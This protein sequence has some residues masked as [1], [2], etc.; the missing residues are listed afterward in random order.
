MLKAQIYSKNLDKKG[1]YKSVYLDFPV[2]RYDLN[3]AYAK[4]KIL[5]PADCG[6]KLDKKSQPRIVPHLERLQ[7]NGLTID[8]LN[9]F[10]KQ[11]NKMDLPALNKLADAINN[12]PAD[13]YRELINIA[14]D[15]YRASLPHEDAADEQP[16]QEYPFSLR[17]SK[18]KDGETLEVR[19]GLPR[20]DDA[21]SLTAYGLT[22]YGY[23]LIG[24]E[25][26]ISAFDGLFDESIDEDMLNRLAKKITRMNGADFVKY[27][28]VL[29]YEHIRSYKSRYSDKNQLL[30]KCIYYADE[31]IKYFFDV[32]V[33]DAASYAE[34]IL[35][36]A[37]LAQSLIDHVNL[38]SYGLAKLEESGA[39]VG[40]YGLV[41]PAELRQ[42]Q[43]LAQYSDSR[44]N[45]NINM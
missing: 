23:S 34:S 11:L 25:T 33:I 2:S 18:L 40:K 15:I 20:E 39:A 28:A 41:E 21:D 30:E 45:M 22:A 27:M 43:A 4:A 14:D 8:N 3:L 38:D 9:Y 36:R 6:I 44:E 13:D 17:M 1:V 5:S 10:A 12:N 35:A 29:D 16:D 24:V 42:E 31:Y 19:V 26:A 32:R 37:G 7:T